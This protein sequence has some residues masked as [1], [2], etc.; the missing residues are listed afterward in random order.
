MNATSI[1]LE[2]TAP[3]RGA[4]RRVPE[5]DEA[6]E[7]MSIERHTAALEGRR[8]P[9]EETGVPSCY[10]E[11]AAGYE[12]DGTAPEVSVIAPAEA[13]A[14]R[15]TSD[16]TDSPGVCAEQQAITDRLAQAVRAYQAADEDH[17]QK[18]SRC[19]QAEGIREMSR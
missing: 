11:D 14:G 2:T 18:C 12:R 6:E 13:T 10:T 19:R 3:C 8:V 4:T 7:T 15:T 9:G 1:K 5:A 16:G 17:L